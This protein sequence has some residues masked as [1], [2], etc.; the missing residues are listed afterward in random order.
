MLECV[1]TCIFSAWVQV[2]V[3]VCSRAEGLFQSTPLPFNQPQSVLTIIHCGPSQKSTSPVNHGLNSTTQKQGLLQ[4]GGFWGGAVGLFVMLI[5]W[6]NLTDPDI[7]CPAC[8]KP[9]IQFVPQIQKAGKTLETAENVCVCVC[10]CYWRCMGKI[11]FFS[12]ACAR[13]IITNR[14]CSCFSLCVC[15]CTL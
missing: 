13:A 15:V 7:C 2:S 3:H 14:E 11:L 5:N 8:V 9:H 6:P 10:P 1:F 4:G 12:P